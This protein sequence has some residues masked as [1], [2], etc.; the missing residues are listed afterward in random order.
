LF[1]FRSPSGHSFLLCCRIMDQFRAAESG[2]LQHLHNTLTVNNVNADVVG[3]T[4]LHFASRDGRT[5]CV[6]YCIEMGA[7]VNARRADGGWTPLQC[8]SYSGHIDVV[9]LLLDAHAGVDA[10][11]D[12]D[13]RTTPLY[14]A[15]GLNHFDIARQL[16]ERG[17]NLSNV[18]LDKNLPV[19]PDWFIALVQ[20]RSNCRNVAIIMIAIHKYHRTAITGKIDINVLKLISKHIWSTRMMDDVWMNGVK[21]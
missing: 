8:A 12:D 1:V 13:T 3:W 9:R 2:D 11:T 6:R 17:A 14:Y 10:T 15:V 18:K 7:N 4:A 16:L 5:D 21:L 20:S 19:L